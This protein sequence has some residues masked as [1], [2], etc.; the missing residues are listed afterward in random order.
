MK[1]LSTVMALV[2]LFA[3]CFFVMA[4]DTTENTLK[5]TASSGEVTAG[6]ELTLTVSFSENT[7]F[8]TLGVKLTYPEGFT[9][10]AD[11]AAP[12]ELI[13]EKCYLSFGGYEGETYEFYHDADA[14]TI[15]FIG[16][17]LYDITDES[18][19]LFTVRFTAPE[20][21]ASGAAFEVEIV[22]DPYN[23][24]GD[25][26]AA[27]TENGAVNVTT[28]YALG[29]VTMNGT[30]DVRDALATLRY[31]TGKTSLT[32]QQLELANVHNSLSTGVDARDALKILRYTTGSITEF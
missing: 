17:S 23:E 25:K 1:K 21:A 2:I 11:S 24:N 26:V 6:Q 5:V 31:T 12:S 4:A 9:Y 15:T 3:S 14:R 29:D 18:G 28:P 19:T 22:D 8:N 10:V 30:I 16:A 7:G 32:E 20:A 13:A 27:G